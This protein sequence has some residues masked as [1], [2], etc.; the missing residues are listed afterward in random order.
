MAI[1]AATLPTPVLDGLRRRQAHQSPKIAC[2][3]PRRLK[4]P[5]GR[6]G[7]AERGEELSMKG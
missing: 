2:A 5:V 4:P 6:T 1:F 3:D 7:K